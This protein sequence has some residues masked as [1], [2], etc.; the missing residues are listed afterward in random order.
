MLLMKI[1][2][3]EVGQAG[4]DRDAWRGQFAVEELELGETL[5]SIPWHLM[6]TL[7]KASK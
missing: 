6:V 1:V 2:P 7:E 3:R 5:L 4:V